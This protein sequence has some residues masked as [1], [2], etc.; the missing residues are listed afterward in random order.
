VEPVDDPEVDELCDKFLRSLGYVGLCEI[1][2]KRDSRDGCVKMIEANPRY[3][4]TADAAPYAGVHLGWL[5][6]LDLIGQPVTPVHGDG[7][8]FRHIFLFLDAMT[9]VNYRKEGLWTWGQIVRSYRSPV[10][11]FDLDWRDWRIA[12]TTLYHSSRALAS[13]LVR[14][15]IPKKPSR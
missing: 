5:H 3:S 12:M 8:D 13:T 1:E 15:I 14:R 10:H 7:K 11:F 6:Y 9:V 4:V 2:L